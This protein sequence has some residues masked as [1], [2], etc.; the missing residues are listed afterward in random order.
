M[1]CRTASLSFSSYYPFLPSVMGLGNLFQ[2]EEFT[3][4]SMLLETVGLQLLFI[5]LHPF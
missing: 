2:N 5:L 1:L 3:A 4:I